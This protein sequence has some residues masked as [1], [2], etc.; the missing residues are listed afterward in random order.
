MKNASLTSLLLNIFFF[1][2]KQI[3]CKHV[4]NREC[5]QWDSW[6]TCKDGISTRICLTDKSL[7]EKQTCTKCDNWSAWSTCVNGKRSRNVTNCPFIREEQDCDPN[8]SEQQNARN[9][10][11]IN[12]DNN[13]EA[14]VDEEKQNDNFENVME[15]ESRL[16]VT[17]D[18]TDVT[19]IEKSTQ[20]EEKN[21]HTKN[22]FAHVM[23]NLHHKNI[24]NHN[25]TLSTTSPSE[26]ITHV[27]TNQGSLQSDEK[28]DNANHMIDTTL[29]KKD[30]NKGEEE[31]EENKSIYD[32]NSNQVDE[33]KIGLSSEPKKSKSF[34][35]NKSDKFPTLPGE[36]V[37]Q[38][39]AIPKHI[40]RNYL[41]EQQGEKYEHEENKSRKKHNTGGEKTGGAPNFNQT[42][43]A[44]G[45]GIIFLLTGSAASYAM[46]AGKYNQLSEEEKPE[47]FEVIF[48][49]DIKVK[50]NNKSMYE[51]EF[52]AIG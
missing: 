42:Y 28:T 27:D 34:R 20:K 17:G 43:I 11:T 35:D 9:N 24:G 18:N 41:Y 32:L 33:A 21:D 7:T 12:F 23:N 47:N 15:T 22:S 37:K 19:F 4:E 39:N 30:S 2:L 48:N 13:N 6:S 25:I 29:E 26:E 1:W 10:I 46:Y 16:P 49:D 14:H 8:A 3:H 51:D 52:W 31:K 45:M 44:S 36:S 38:I 50:E 5:K 40:N